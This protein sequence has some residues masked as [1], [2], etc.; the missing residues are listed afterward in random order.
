MRRVLVL[1]N[2]TGVGGTERRLGRLF[3]HMAEE[4]KDTVFVINRGLW[5]KLV[6][7]ALVPERGARVVR[8][9]EPFG[10]VAERFAAI[11]PRAQFWIRKLDYVL[12][13]A[14]LLL[15]YGL[16]APRLFH[17][18]LGGAYVARPLM[19]VRRSHRYVISVTD[20]NLAGHVGSAR[21]LPLFRAAI[22]RSH[23]VDALTEDIKVSLVRDGVAPNRILCSMG[24]V[25]DV[26]RFRPAATKQPL[27]VFA[28]RLVE[29]KD[30]L[31]FLDAIPA[32]HQAMPEARF[33]L[34]GDGPLRGSVELAV[35]RLGIRSI[36]TTGFVEDLAP[37]LSRACI[38]VSLQ[39]RDNFPS[40]G[41]LEAMA[42]GAATVATDVG[43][44]WKLV[45]DETGI[46]IRRSAGELAHAV[47]AL[48]RTPEQCRMMGERARRR[49]ME[50]HSEDQYR[51][52]LQSLY[53]RVGAAGEMSGSADRPSHGIP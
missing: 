46:R 18:V 2:N 38:F 9:G 6:A 1:I 23:A 39:Q 44:T 3:A 45:D 26:T 8:L 53:A 7:G 19:S 36:V 14:W 40:Q 20:P 12:M 35:D 27:V 34:F 32:V 13:A 25:V 17:I 15:R 29:E 41:L 10:R 47:V 52:Y 37:T 51:A 43:L 28:G 31:L 22:G 50:H 21:A 42:S 48:L 5:A 16:A 30:P 4:E 11:G 24:S 49:V 33:G